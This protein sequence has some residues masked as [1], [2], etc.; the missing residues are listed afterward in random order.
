MQGSDR[1]LPDVPLSTGATSGRDSLLATKLH[2]PGPNPEFVPRP[3]LTEW[4]DHGLNRSLVLVCAP[5]GYGK[6]TVLADWA[7]RGPRPVACR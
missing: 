5:A 1:E 6:T 2:M 4:L 7:R 3:R